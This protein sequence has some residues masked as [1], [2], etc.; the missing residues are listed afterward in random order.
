MTAP[1]VGY[2]Q[3]LCRGLTSCGGHL[4]RPPDPQKGAPLRV[5]IWEYSLLSVS[6]LIL[7]YLLVDEQGKG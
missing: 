1:V 4:E 7:I 2:N 3:T 5:V 6:V